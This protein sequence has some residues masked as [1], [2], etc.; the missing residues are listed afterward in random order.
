M[1]ARSAPVDEGFGVA[2][3]READLHCRNEIARLEYGL[4]QGPAVGVPLTF[5]LRRRSSC[6]ARGSAKPPTRYN[7]GPRMGT[8][9]RRNRIPA[10]VQ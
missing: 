4:G 2:C 9:F 3:G 5:S 8:L 1:A 6:M 7:G 10:A